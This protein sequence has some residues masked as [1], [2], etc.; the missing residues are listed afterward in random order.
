MH[1]LGEVGEFHVDHISV[2]RSFFHHIEQAD[3]I[4]MHQIPNCILRLRVR[5]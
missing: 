2:L 1:K 4:T 3:H 5:E